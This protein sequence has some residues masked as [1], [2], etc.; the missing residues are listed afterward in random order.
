MPQIRRQ[1]ALSLLANSA[2]GRPCYR[3]RYARGRSSNWLKVKNPDA[4]AVRRER[5]EEWG[6]DARY[7]GAHASLEEFF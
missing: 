4:P 3:L 7:P 1:R 2:D 6:G 5:V